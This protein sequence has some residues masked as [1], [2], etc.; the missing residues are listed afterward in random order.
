MFKWFRNLKICNDNINW[1]N[2]KLSKQ[3]SDIFYMLNHYYDKSS[4]NIAV[5]GDIDKFNRLVKYFDT[6]FR[7]SYNPKNWEL[8][9]RKAIKINNSKVTYMVEDIELTI[10]HINTI[11]DLTKH[12]IR[13]KKYL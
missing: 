7:V 3:D 10:V 5:L 4:P 2:L 6:I 11:S 13:Y 1:D 8:T 12:N 9:R